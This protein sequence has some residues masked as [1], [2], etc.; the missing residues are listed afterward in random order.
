M[1]RQSVALRRDR[2]RPKVGVFQRWI[3]FDVGASYSLMGGVMFVDV[4]VYVLQLLCLLGALTTLIATVVPDYV[5][6]KPLNTEQR[7]EQR[8]EYVILCIGALVGLA[9]LQMA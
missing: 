3:W 6:G 1:L 7:M 2:L 4:V 8:L 9:V 5:A